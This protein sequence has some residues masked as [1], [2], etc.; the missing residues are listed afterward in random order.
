MPPQSATLVYPFATSTDAAL[1]L[2]ATFDGRRLTSD[3]GLP[4]LAE[5]EE[6]LGICAAVSARRTRSGRLRHPCG[7]IPPL[8]L[9][10]GTSRRAGSLPADVRP[11]S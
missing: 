7:L 4:W 10:G 1:P 3:C 6:A 2:D 9:H 8:V 11:L 5:A